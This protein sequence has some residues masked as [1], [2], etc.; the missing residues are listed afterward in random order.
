MKRTAATILT[1]LI[2][3]SLLAVPALAGDGAPSTIPHVFYGQVYNVDGSNAPAGSIIVA[4]VAGNPV[5]TTTVATAGQYGVGPHDGDATK[6]AV[7]SS[8]ISPGDTITFSIYG[9]T[10]KESAVYESGGFT[11]LTLTA[12]R[13]LYVR[14]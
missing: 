11:N 2:A 7:W 1:L 3:V 9:V 10:A 6:F 4:S 13:F 12:R 8:A 5:G 14:I